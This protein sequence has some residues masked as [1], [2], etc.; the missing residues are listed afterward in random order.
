MATGLINKKRQSAFT[1]SCLFIFCLLL[2]SSKAYAG[3][4]ELIETN[5]KIDTGISSIHFVDS[6]KGF[7]VTGFDTI[8]LTKDGGKTWEENYKVAIEGVKMP[9][10]RDVF[11]V[12]RNHGW[13]VGDDNLILHT[14]T[15]GL[16]W[17]PQDSSL[18][19]FVVRNRIGMSV[20][21]PKDIASVFFINPKEGWAVGG[22]GSIVHTENGGLTWEIQ[23]GSVRDIYYGVFFVDKDHGWIV[24]DSGKILHTTTGG[25]SLFGF[26]GWKAQKSGTHVHLFGV[27]FVDKQTGWAVGAKEVIH[28]TNGGETWNV[29]A[30]F[31][32]TSS[33]RAVYFVDRNT[34]WVSGTG[35]IQ[36]TRDGG[37]TWIAQPIPT[38]GAISLHCVDAKHCWAASETKKILRY[39]SE[40]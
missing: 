9:E 31:K 32:E 15:G 40:P 2:I 36:H 12:D 24:G 16:V 22:F 39:K 26:G 25:K 29:Q 30:R 35:P 23:K 5:L 10:L 33:L 6:Q 4:W 13:V 8:L 27:H 28:T 21:M 18:N 17:F 1:W 11:F 14:N 37:K 38:Y 34:G 3:T 19:P 7:A 20:A